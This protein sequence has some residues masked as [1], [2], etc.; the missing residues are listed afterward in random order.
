[1]KVDANIS[2]SHMDQNWTRYMVM[3]D[4]DT[5]RKPVEFQEDNEVQV[6]IPTNKPLQKN[7]ELVSPVEKGIQCTPWVL[8]TPV[9]TVHNSLVATGV[10]HYEGGW[11]RDIDMHDEELTARYRRK[12]EK[13]EAYLNQ[14]KGLGKVSR[15]RGVLWVRSDID[16]RN[17]KSVFGGTSTLARAGSDGQTVS[18]SIRLGN[19]VKRC[20]LDIKKAICFVFSSIF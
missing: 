2:V 13:S 6:T 20:N 1:M 7:F 4:T 18:P 8:N 16:S 9:W 5:L 11:P 3:A 14:M 17:K 12:Q 19:R 10:T 15:T